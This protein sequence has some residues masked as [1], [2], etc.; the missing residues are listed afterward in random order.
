MLDGGARLLHLPCLPRYRQRHLNHLIASLALSTG[1]QGGQNRRSS[2]VASTRKGVV[3]QHLRRLTAMQAFPTGKWVGQSGKN[4]GV[5]SMVAKAVP[6]SP[7]QALAHRRTAMLDSQTGKQH[8]RPRKNSGVA[9]MSKEVVN[10]N[11]LL[12][13]PFQKA[14]VGVGKLSFP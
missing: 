7:R 14:C 9:Y 8:G 4:N 3:Q 13:V 11:D 1:K 6:W 12:A 5:V 10:D 2:G